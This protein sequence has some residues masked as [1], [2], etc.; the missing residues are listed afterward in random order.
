MY[1]VRDYEE[2][3]NNNLFIAKKQHTTISKPSKPITFPLLISL[4]QTYSNFHSFDQPHN[5]C[6]SSKFK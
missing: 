2:Q 1:R 4:I 5:D 6:L 3:D